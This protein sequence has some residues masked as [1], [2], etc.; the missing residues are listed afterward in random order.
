VGTE[1]SVLNNYYCL[2]NDDDDNIQY[3]V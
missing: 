1:F 3:Y 2:K